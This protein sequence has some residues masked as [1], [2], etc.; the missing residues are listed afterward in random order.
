MRP[1]VVT[2]TGA[3]AVDRDAVAAQ[4][5]LEPLVLERGARLERADARVGGGGERHRGAGEL[6][7]LDRAPGARARA[8]AGR[9]RRASRRSRTAAGSAAG[10]RRGQRGAA[11][12]RA[13]R[14]PPPRRAARAASRASAWLSASV[15]AISPSG[16][17]D[18][19]QPLAGEVHAQ[20]AGGADAR[21]GGAQ[22]VQRRRA[23]GRAGARLGR[24]GAAV[25]H[26]QHLVL[27]RRHALLR[28][29]R[30]DAAA[31]ELL[32]VAGRHHHARAQRRIGRGEDR[33]GS[34]LPCSTSSRPAS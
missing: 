5:A 15:Q 29:E 12:D 19:V 6:V 32:L 1:E 33:H 8:P 13:A 28:R 3:E 25:E 24:V 21:A 10:L 16:A 23:G 4:H 30:R 2:R 26:E 11:A 18:R 34:G 17:P 27:G 31:D 20:R 14:R 22:H 9:G 7:V